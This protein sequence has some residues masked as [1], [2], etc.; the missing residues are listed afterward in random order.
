MIYRF[1]E[2]YSS[3]KKT[4]PWRKFFCVSELKLLAKST[5][6]AGLRRTEEVHPLNFK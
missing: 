1:V 5:V 2:L 3:E 4:A 6:L